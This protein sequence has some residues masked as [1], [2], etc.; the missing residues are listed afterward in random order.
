MRVPLKSWIRPDYA[1]GVLVG[2]CFRMAQITTR[3]KKLRPKTFIGACILRERRRKGRPDWWV[4]NAS[5]GRHTWAFEDDILL[6]TPSE[7]EDFLRGLAVVNPDL[8][9]TILSHLKKYKEISLLL[10]R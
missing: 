5:T 10:G 3:T 2:E 7:E 4:I 1:A 9:E 8:C 6:L